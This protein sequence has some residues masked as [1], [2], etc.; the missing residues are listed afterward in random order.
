MRQS[1]VILEVC[2]VPLSFSFQTHGDPDVIAIPQGTAIPHWAYL[3]VTVCR[4]FYLLLGQSVHND[5]QIGDIFNT[6]L[7][8]SAGRKYQ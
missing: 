4:D 5:L 3:N 2:V 6:T 8:Q 7:A 1:I